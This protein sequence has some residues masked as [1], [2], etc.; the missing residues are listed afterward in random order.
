MG[1][2]GHD[3]GTVQVRVVNAVADESVVVFVVDDNAGRLVAGQH[4]A[5]DNHA[6]VSREAA[7]LEREGHMA[8]HLT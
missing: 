3:A 6:E 5:L 1:H 8:E 2:A 4:R 7:T